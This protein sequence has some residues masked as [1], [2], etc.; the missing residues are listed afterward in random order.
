MSKRK[1]YKPE[2]KAKVAL[3]AL[4]GEQTVSEL[5][6]RFGVHPTMI[7]QWKKAL[8]EGASELFERGSSTK[9]PAVDEGK[10][11]ALHAKIG[12]LTVAN[13]FLFRK[14]QTMDRQVRRSMVEHNRA[15]LPVV[16][17]CQLLSISRS[18]FYAT[19]CGESDINLAIMAEIDRQF[20]DTPFYG[21]RQMTWHL[22]G[23]GWQINVK[24]VRRL[25]RKMGLMPIYQQ[26]KTSTPAPGHKIYPYLLRD[27]VIDRP[28]QVWCTDITYIPLARGFLY[29]V[30][31][32]DWWSRKVL[33]WRL[34]NTMEAAFCV[35]TLEEAMDRHGK[36][37]I[38]NTD[39]GS[40]FTSWDFTQK[41]KDAGIRISMDGKGRWLDNVFVER[42]W[43]SLKY[44]CVYLHAWTGGR[45]AR[46][47]IGSW[48]AF[49]NQQRPHA[50]HDGQTP[51]AVYHQPDTSP[52]AKMA[53]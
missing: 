32:M 26:P 6:S 20:L 27:L 34:S 2:F 9:E 38:F 11:K 35:D 40:Q 17:Q 25:M 23:K 16:R 37:E 36:P 44:E 21:V 3:E 45:E 42:L 12:E 24:R 13:D 53:A 50:A 43:R 14:A 39:Q 29:L 15:D 8:L 28:N 48:M 10:V 33:A 4:K 51:D 22:R 7:H 46:D 18:S 1:Q 19:P 41:I 52:P 5:A 49:Y 47:G 31:I 30:A